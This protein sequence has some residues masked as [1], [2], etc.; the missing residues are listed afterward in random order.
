MGA[1]GMKEKSIYILMPNSIHL[2]NL[3]LIFDFLNYL[4]IFII[5]FCFS[6]LFSNQSFG[7]YSNIKFVN[8]NTILT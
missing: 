6:I 3:G 4:I 1:F 7:V 8:E 5:Q 2:E